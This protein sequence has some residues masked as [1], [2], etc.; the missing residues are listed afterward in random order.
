MRKKTR[1]K[2]EFDRLRELADRTGL[3]YRTLYRAG[4]EG[5]IK[6]LKLGGT[7]LV[8]RREVQRILEQGF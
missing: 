5:K 3:C 6:I 2:R 4:K 7:L 1:K 8:P